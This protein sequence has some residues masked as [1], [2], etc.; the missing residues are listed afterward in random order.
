M[1]KLIFTLSFFV[2]L[3][4]PIY[5]DVFGERC[6]YVIVLKNPGTNEIIEKFDTKNTEYDIRMLY[7]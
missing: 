3:L 6:D 2:L 1:I 7:Y 4:V 5:D